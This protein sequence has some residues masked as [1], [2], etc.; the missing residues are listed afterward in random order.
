MPGELRPTTSAGTDTNPLMQVTILA[1][2]EDVKRTG[3][4]ESCKAT[5]SA[6]RQNPGAA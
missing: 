5:G 2:T 3:F 6:L 1:S 4:L